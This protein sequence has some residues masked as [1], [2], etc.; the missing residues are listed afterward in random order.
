MTATARPQRLRYRIPAVMRQAVSRAVRLGVE[1]LKAEPPQKLADWA[2]DHFVLSGDSSHRQGQWQ[3][4]PFQIAWL[5]A[6]SNDDI[7]QVDVRKAKRTGYTKCLVAFVAYNAAHRRRKL[8]LYQPTDDDR[9]SFVKSEIDP[10][11][12]EVP[13]VRAARRM[14]KGAEDTIKFKTYRGSVQHFLG[15]K[16]ARAYRRITVAVVLLDEIDAFDQQVEKSSDP[17]TLARGRLEGAPFPKLV[18]GT[19]PRL[20]GFSHIDRQEQAADARLR[21]RITCPHCDCEHPLIWGDGKVAHGFKWDSSAPKPELTACH[22]CPHCHG[23]ITQADYLRIWRQGA[24]VCDATGVRY[25]ADRTWRAHDG[26]PIRAPRHVA[27]CGLWAAYSPQRTWSDI[28]REGREAYR[29]KKAGDSGPLQ[30]FVNETLA[31]C[32]EEDYEQTDTEILRRRA[33]AEGLPMGVVPRGAAVLK[34]SFDVQA[35][36]WEMVTW[37]FGPENE[38]WAID[39]RVI[40]G[41]TGDQDEWDAK[42]EP[43]LGISYPTATGARL[44]C[45]SCAID[46]GYQT[47]QAY[48]FARKHRARNVHAVKGDSQAGKPIKARR[49]L[50]DINTKGRVLRKGVAL[51]YVGTDTAKDLIHGRLQLEGSGPG[52]MHF[53]ADLPDA[54]FA[55]LTAEQRIPMRT[56]RGVEYRWDCPSGRRNEPLDCTVYCLFLAELDDLPR[57]TDRQWG[58]AMSALELDLFDAPQPPAQTGDAITLPARQTAPAPAAPPAVH[59]SA[60]KHPRPPRVAATIGSDEWQSR[61]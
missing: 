49:S 27:F 23:S 37:A 31:E 46:T 41:N 32:Y 53:A 16:A 17:I 35:D 22:V 18:C 20:K 2:R 45:G 30:G 33:K 13:A 14:A 51:W 50:Q 52:R 44:A 55:G 9:D 61:L 12:A 38:S 40:Y 57:W 10:M 34:Q 6:F 19:T 29:A 21:Y 48:A 8:A 3:A 54:F 15:G 28:V 60:P 4:W 59:T 56:V 42:V 7:Q 25:G 26:A 1:P 58:R 5:D 11:V 39:Y 43:L 47:H 36:R 24:W